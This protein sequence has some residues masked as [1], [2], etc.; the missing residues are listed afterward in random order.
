VKKLLPLLL[1]LAGI[2]SAQTSTTI[3]PISERYDS[4]LTVTDSDGYKI[5]IYNPTALNGFMSYYANGISCAPV[6]VSTSYSGPLPSIQ[7]QSRQPTFHNT[8]SCTLESGETE[9]L[10][11]D[12]YV[13]YKRSSGGRAGGNAGVYIQVQS[14]TF[15]EQ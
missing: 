13:Y 15:T 14:G 6:N 1:L 10:T 5:H 7:Y 4:D 9:T 11:I 3:Q 2:A 12:G 8:Y